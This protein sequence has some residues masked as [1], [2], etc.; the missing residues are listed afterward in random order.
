MPA[1]I[2]DAKQQRPLG[3]DSRN[4]KQDVRLSPFLTS[5][6]ETKRSRISIFPKKLTLKNGRDSNDK[7]VELLQ[8]GR[9]QTPSLQNPISSTASVEQRELATDSGI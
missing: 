4:G 3:I 1:I 5:G 6:D 9:R 7:H 8:S 2:T